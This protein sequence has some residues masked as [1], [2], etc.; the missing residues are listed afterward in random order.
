MSDPIM[1]GC[2]LHDKTML[3]KIAQGR[4]PPETLTVRNTRADRARLVAQLQAR[5]AA[6]GGVRVLVAYEASGLGFGWCDELRTAGLECYVLAPTKLARSARQQTN[7]TDERDAQA[8]LELLRG[9]VLAGNALPSV[10]V[11]DATTRDD[12]ELVRA[13]LDLTEKRTTIKT[14]LKCLLKRSGLVR[15]E[16]AGTGW[17]KRYRGWLEW[18]TLQEDQP[19]GLRRTLASLL[20]QLSFHEAELARVDEGL[21]ALASTPRYVAAVTELNQLIGVG[22]L[23]ALVFLVEVGDVQRFANRRQ[24]SAYLGLAPIA[25]E[26]GDQPDRKGHITRQGPSRVRKVLCQAAWAR[27]RRDSGEEQVYERIVRRN[28]RKKKVALVA[29]MRRLA[30]R[31]WHRACAAQ[32]LASSPPPEGSACNAPAKEGLARRR[33]NQSAPKLGRQRPRP[34]K[35]G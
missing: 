12:R 17:T 15:P 25:D 29:V 13:R 7:K 22:L 5:S 18:L 9:H 14:Q 28:P 31:M 23:T 3:L 2:D 30:V 26:S 34:K 6:A 33:P 1:V 27:V 4:N 24:I 35:A 21:L 10:W 32:R 8:L 19:L 11:P 16:S 20:R